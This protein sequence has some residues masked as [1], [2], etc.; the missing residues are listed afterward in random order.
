M[1]NAP[2]AMVPPLPLPVDPAG[3]GFMDDDDFLLPPPFPPG[4]AEPTWHQLKLGRVVSFVSNL[5]NAYGVPFW[6]RDGVDEPDVNV[7]P[8][9]DQV[10]RRVDLGKIMTHVL[11]AL[12]TF[13]EVYKAQE[14]TDADA[15][16]DPSLIA[17]RDRQRSEMVVFRAAL[18]HTADATSVRR[19]DFRMDLL[20]RAFPDP[21]KIIPADVPVPP[22]AV[23]GAPAPPPPPP[24]A[25]VRG[26]LPLHWAVLFAAQGEGGVT[27]EDVATLHEADPAAMHRHHQQG[28]GVTDQGDLIDPTPHIP[29]PAF[30]RDLL[31]FPV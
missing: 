18:N 26:W 5:E 8:P 28:I 2:L 29:R 12:E 1:N 30:R 20:L 3:L 24:P 15:A 16:A 14:V 19:R 13:V 9:A 6:N 11:D 21:M 7:V 23:D 22:P 17:T 25:P 31:L 10:C 4:P 27:E